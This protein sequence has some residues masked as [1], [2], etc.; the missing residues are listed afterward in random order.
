MNMPAHPPHT[1]SE[2]ANERRRWRIVLAAIC[3]VVLLASIHFLR[4]ALG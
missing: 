4:T 1:D 3:I 2:P